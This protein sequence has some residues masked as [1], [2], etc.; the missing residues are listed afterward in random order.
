[1]HDVHLLNGSVTSMQA[2]EGWIPDS[3]HTL[4]NC[5]S[6]LQCMSQIQDTTDTAGNWRL[7]IRYRLLLD[8]PLAWPALFRAPAQNGLASI[9]CSMMNRLQTRYKTAAWDH[10]TTFQVLSG[11]LQAVRSFVTAI[12]TRLVTGNEAN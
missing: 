7:H 11:F 6:L 5:S 10:W 3:D 1:M 2:H 4:D 8:A 9:N 12:S